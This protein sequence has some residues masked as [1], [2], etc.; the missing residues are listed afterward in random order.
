MSNFLRAVIVAATLT[1]SPSIAHPRPTREQIVMTMRVHVCE[2]SSAGW[3]VDVDGYGGGLGWKDA[4]W[5]EYRSSWMPAVAWLA[6]RWEQVLAMVNF[7][8]ANGWP[9]QTGCQ[10]GGY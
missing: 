10:E 7:A 6:P 4:T 8:R 2:E 5:S 9:D 3:Q 1:F